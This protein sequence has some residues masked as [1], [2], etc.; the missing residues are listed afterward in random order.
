MA[1]EKR[2]AETQMSPR[3]VNRYSL[4]VD[5]SGFKYNHTADKTPIQYMEINDYWNNKYPARVLTIYVP[6]PD[7]QG[8]VHSEKVVVNNREMYPINVQV[9]PMDSEGFLNKPFVDGSFKAILRNGDF[10][11]TFEDM[12]TGQD[13]GR[14]SSRELGQSRIPLTFYLYKDDELSYSQR[15]INL[16]MNNPTLTQAW[17]NGFHKSNPKLSSIVS[18]F[19]HN[20]NMGMLVIPPSGYPDFLEYLD[21]EVGFYRTGYIDYVAHGIYFLL[22]KD[23]DFKC[24]CPD[25]EYKIT[26]TVGRSLHTNVGKYVRK[27]DETNYEI[28]VGAPDVKV[29]ISNDKSFGKSVKYI[30]P[31]GKVTTNARGLSRNCDVVYKTT[32][33]PHI[34]KLE[35]PVYEFMETRM[36]SSI[37]FVTPLTL[38]T[39]Q[40]ST[41]RPRQY[42]VA[43]HQI[44]IVAG[45]ETE[46][47]L[48]GFRLL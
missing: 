9:S 17:F 5:I 10:E 38:I 19:D 18:Q 16:V 35:N 24:S 40:D 48:K 12:I 13:G 30:H 21:D 33:I 14:L 20:P 42:R 46:T 32:E 41:G 11:N 29:T 22:N 28:A 44:R 1:E 39:M 34:D 26:L 6:F 8:I 4:M 31:S 23:N 7:V 45:L 25:L 15:D 2:K 43:S 3:V 27:L 36:P 47:Y 37:N